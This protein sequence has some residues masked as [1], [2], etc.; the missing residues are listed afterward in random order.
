MEKHLNRLILVLIALVAFMTGT[1]S[2]SA[3]VE[4]VYGKAVNLK[5][6]LEFLEEHIVKYENDRIASIKTI[7]YDAGLKKIGEQISDFSHG[8]Q[9]G[10]YDF[11]DER[12]QYHDGA[13][14]MADQILIYCKE[15]PETGTK[16][17]YLRKDSNQIVGQGF[18]QFIV[19]NLDSLV[20]GDVITAKL[21]LPAHMD[22][23]DIRIF[24]RKI[25]N[26]RIQIQIE[27]D[28]WFLRLFTPHLEAEYDLASRRLLSY[29]GLSMI[30]DLSGKTKEVKVSYNYSQ[31]RPLLSSLFKSK[32]DGLE[33]D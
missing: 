26:G 10:S 6:E 9:Y 21:V 7:Y 32:A 8:P 31:Q 15:T 13:R 17:K 30:S 28:N 5:G 1:R 24:K 29:R 23:F 11:K 4:W 12:L 22:Q 14:V 20:R 33:R 3:D 27:L 18:H 19:A 2:A 16:D 25:E